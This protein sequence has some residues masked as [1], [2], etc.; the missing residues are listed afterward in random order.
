MKSLHTI[1]RSRLRRAS[2]HAVACSLIVPTFTGAGDNWTAFQ[3]SGVPVAATNANWGELSPGNIVWQAALPGSGQ[4][5]P[6]V[7]NGVVYATSVSGAN[8]ETYHLIAVRLE[9]GEELWRHEVP[10]ASPQESSEYVSQAAPT[11]IVDDRG[12]IA[13]YEGGNLVALT[14]AGEVRWERNL[15]AELGAIDGRH[16]LGGSLE[17]SADAVFVWVE[18]STDPYLLCLDKETGEPRWKVP[19]LGTTSWASPRLIPVAG[20]THL[21][22][23]GVGQLVGIDPA[24]GDRLWEFTELAGNSTPTPV[25][26]AKGRFLVGATV[27]REGGDTAGAAK[28]NGLI[29][30]VPAAGGGWSVKYVWHAESAT[31][32]FGSPAA[33][34]GHAYFVNRAG[35]L[36]CLNLETGA[37]EYAQRLS[38]SIWATPIV[39]NDRIIF[40]IKEGSLQV[41]SATAKFKTLA[42]LSLLP[43]E[44][45]PAPAGDPAATGDTAAAQ[46]ANPTLYAGILCNGRLLARFGNRIVCVALAP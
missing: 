15:V 24:T 13:F 25:P 10:N 43:T 11:P 27:G 5:S 19:G 17:Q 44:A 12:V 1:C 2:L 39:T 45:D 8:K 38:G 18:R 35:V 34:A 14:H 46:P 4:S 40:G 33:A 20:G 3:N 9:D 22:L 31:S 29:E 23:S 42:E 30:V 16:G 32:S 21:V 28:S 7:W 36:Y 26:V 6:V 41:V 37:E